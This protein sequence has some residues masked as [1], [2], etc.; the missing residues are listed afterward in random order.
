MWRQPFPRQQHRTVRSELPPA[1]T[2]FFKLLPA[3]SSCLSF[4]THCCTDNTDGDVTSLLRSPRVNVCQDLR[5]ISCNR[6]RSRVF[7]S[8]LTGY[9]CVMHC[10]SRNWK[11]GV[12]SRNREVFFVPESESGVL[13]FLT[14]ESGDHKKTR[15]PHPCWKHTSEAKNLCQNCLFFSSKIWLFSIAKWKDRYTRILSLKYHCV[16]KQM[17]W[18]D[19]ITM[20]SLR[21]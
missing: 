11:P 19:W 20:A 9:G 10:L 4:I 14:L 16:A 17:P 8:G 5:L 21:V 15:T 2:V 18:F 7:V 13:N 6:G 1:H 12:W 3:V